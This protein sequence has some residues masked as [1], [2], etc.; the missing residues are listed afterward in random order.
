MEQNCPAVKNGLKNEALLLDNFRLPSNF[1]Q[2]FIAGAINDAIPKKWIQLIVSSLF[3]EKSKNENSCKSNR[4]I[5]KYCH[6]FDCDI[7]SPDI[8]LSKV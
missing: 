8:F 6:F 1:H 5:L 2:L 4:H 7:R 3:I